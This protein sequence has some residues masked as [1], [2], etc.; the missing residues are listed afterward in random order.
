MPDTSHSRETQ[1]AGA[2]HFATTQWTAVLA[3]GRSDSTHARAALEKLCRDY[4]FPLYAFARRQGHDAPDAQDLTQ[5]FF[6]RLLE[7]NYLADVRREK[8]RFRSF[9][10][11]AMKHFLANEWHRANAQKRGGGQKFIPLEAGDAE[12][13]Y[14][15]EPAH[16]ESPDKLFE[17][18]WALTL[19]ELVLKRLRA[20]HKAA[21]KVKL[22]DAL[23]GCLTGDRAT[24]PY[25]EIGATVG[26][27]EGAVK[28]AV[29]RLRERYRRLLR[30]EIAN[31]VA[32]E[33]DIEDE[34]RHLLTALAG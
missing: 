20:E 16:N 1:P 7:K 29:H 24:L 25:A 32:N 26:M 10:L 11:A 17:R 9:L 6:A 14:G 31:T 34:L 18:R 4:W 5:E 27:S 23:K 2:A 30:D 13:R 8:G 3:A 21:G 19:L 15:V 22:F 28:V 12:S 33:K